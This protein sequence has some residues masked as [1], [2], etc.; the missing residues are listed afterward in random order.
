[1]E[2]LASVR[3]PAARGPAVPRRQQLIRLSGAGW[4]HVL[5]APW[6]ATA[7][8]CLGLWAARGLPL[9]VT[10]QLAL[11]EALVAAGL[12]APA[13]YRR[14]RLALAVAPQDVL[15]FDEFPTAD[16]ATRL[17]PRALAAAW[18]N[19]LAALAAADCRPRVY[20]GYGWQSLTRLAYVHADSDIDLLLPVTDVQHADVVAHV[21]A[22]ASWG[23]PRLDGELLFPDGGAVAWREWRDCR[24]GRVS[25]VLVKRLRGVALET[26]AASP[27]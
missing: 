13:R 5:E 27:A 16:A 15:F 6:D 3:S 24:Q 14:R 22:T 7:R 1:M 10:R 25:Q 17:L 11:Q 21:L 4:T 18:R 2:P 12:P 20:G 23:G 8:S 9:V 26:L 19:L